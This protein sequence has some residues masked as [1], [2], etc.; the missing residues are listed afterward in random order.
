MQSSPSGTHPPPGAKRILIFLQL[1]ASHPNHPHPRPVLFHH[2]PR[3]IA[4][5]GFP[6]CRSSSATNFGEPPNDK[7]ITKASWTF[8]E[9]KRRPP[10][11]S[12]KPHIPAPQ[13]PKPLAFPPSCHNS[14]ERKKTIL[15]SGSESVDSGHA[16][17]LP[18]PNS[19]P[20]P[21]STIPNRRRR[22]QIAAVFHSSSL[23]H[24]P[25]PVR[26][27]APLHMVALSGLTPR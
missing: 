19:T 20:P 23:L 5:V 2:P 7:K 27:H 12:K 17:P 3:A 22:P 14:S 8:S 10:G 4:S 25:V 13:N 15:T 9:K 6:I 16:F 26:H 18:Y 21:T 24:L 11:I 1:I